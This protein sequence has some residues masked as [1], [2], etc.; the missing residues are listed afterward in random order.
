VRI[1]AAGPIPPATGAYREAF[2]SAVLAQKP[3][4]RHKGDFIALPHS[5]SPHRDRHTILHRFRFLSH[6]VGKPADDDAAVPKTQTT[7]RNRRTEAD[8][9]RRF[10]VVLGF[11]LSRA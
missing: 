10:P 8:E 2:C 5:S 1:F 11:A 7:V 6:Y 3:R 9:S 4:I